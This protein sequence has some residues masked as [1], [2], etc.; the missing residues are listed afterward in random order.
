MGF[1]S[2]VKLNRS[3]DLILI[4]TM[5]SARGMDLDV[6]PVG[7]VLTGVVD[8]VSVL[9]DKDGLIVT[10]LEVGDEKLFLSEMEYD[11]HTYDQVMPFPSDDR[12]KHYTY[13]SIRLL[14]HTSLRTDRVLIKIVDNINVVTEY[15]MT[16]NPD[17][18]KH[19]NYAETLDK[20]VIV[21]KTT[22]IPLDPRLG[23]GSA[24]WVRGDSVIPMLNN[25]EVTEAFSVS[26]SSSIAET[27]LFYQFYL[28]TANDNSD[29]SVY[30]QLNDEQIYGFPLNLDISHSYKESTYIEIQPESTYKILTIAQVG[31]KG[32]QALVYAANTFIFK[33]KQPSKLLSVIVL[34]IIGDVTAYNEDY[35]FIINMDAPKEVTDY[36]VGHEVLP[37]SA[38]YDTA[39]EQGISLPQFNGALYIIVTG[40]ALFLLFWRSRR[41]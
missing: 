37:A 3:L 14:T 10:W 29:P 5:F 35:M 18:I 41:L 11:A 1:T 34:S 17:T 12:S 31:T 2:Y 25:K 8:D 24:N 4:E 9:I 23:Y 13:K 21:G 16:F 30:T 20:Y 33:V 32:K 26:P 38:E 7:D 19:W 22:E 27:D 28:Y 15:P 39:T 6:T 36:L 40:V